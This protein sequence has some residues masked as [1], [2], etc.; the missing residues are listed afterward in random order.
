MGKPIETIEE[1]RSYALFVQRVTGNPM[2]IF[3]ASPLSMGYSLG[4]RFGICRED[5]RDAYLSDGAV[6]VEAETTQ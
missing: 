6:F 2:L 3:K 5:E 1:A 4:W